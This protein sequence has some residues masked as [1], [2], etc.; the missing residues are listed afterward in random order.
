MNNWILITGASSGIGRETAKHLDK[1]GYSLV[2]VART[3]EKLKTLEVELENPSL[4]CAT[5][6]C[7]L[8][9][10]EEIFH[11]CAEKK[12]Q[13]AGLVHCAGVGNNTPVRSNEIEEMENT[14]T[15]NY[16]SFMEL[17][18]YFGMRKYSLEGASI[19]AVSSISPLTC[20]SGSC[21]YAA[22]KSAI[23]T[24]VKVM[25]KEYLRRKIRV[26]A[27]LPGYVNTPLG[28][29]EDDPV[30]IEQQPLGIIK[31]PYV[32]YLIEF[33]LSDKSRYMTGTLIPISG[34]MSY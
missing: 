4:I 13:L 9:K 25:A 26:N 10:I 34:G 7:E 32:A 28:P 33:L 23:N 5:D 18:K 22:S 30:Y 6:L 29:D 19:V 17:V 16:Y 8:A 24:A 20:Y 2:L 21:N 14:M 11:K 3:N 12:I 31:A 1:C 27:V 15:T